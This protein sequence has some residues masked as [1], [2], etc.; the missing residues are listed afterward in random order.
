MVGG[1]GLELSCCHV[2]NLH[3]IN[4]NCVPLSGVARAVGLILEQ[5]SYKSSV[6]AHTVL[7]EHVVIYCTAAV[8]H[9]C[10]PQCYALMQQCTEA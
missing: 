1:S 2:S 8:M 6:T 5:R 9:C 7:F 3:S 4:V 10:T